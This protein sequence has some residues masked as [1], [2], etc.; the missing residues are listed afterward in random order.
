M[1]GDNFNSIFLSEILHLPLFSAATGKEIG[2]IVGH[3][4]II[5][6]TN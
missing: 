5:N 4:L 2:R 6:S 3:I 1:S